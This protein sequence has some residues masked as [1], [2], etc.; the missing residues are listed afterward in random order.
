M[1]RQ[2]RKTNACSFQKNKLD[3]PHANMSKGKGCQDRS[4]RHQQADKK[5]F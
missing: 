3:K 5:T 1:G 2:F 4:H